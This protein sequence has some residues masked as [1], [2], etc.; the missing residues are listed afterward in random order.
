[1]SQNKLDVTLQGD[2]Q[3][4]GNL[5]TTEKQGAE[6]LDL[7]MGQTIEFKKYNNDGADKSGGTDKNASNQ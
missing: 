4:K 5:E 6:T 1:M 3:E 7:T 2:E